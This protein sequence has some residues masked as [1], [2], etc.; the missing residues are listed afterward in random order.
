MIYFR[1]ETP[2]VLKRT[3]WTLEVMVTNKLAIKGGILVK[4]LWMILIKSHAT[5]RIFKIRHD[6]TSTTSNALY[7]AYCKLCGHHVVGPTV[8]WKPWL[9]NYKSHISKFKYSCRIVKH[10]VEVYVDTS[11]KSLFRFAW[12]TKQWWQSYQW[13]YRC[14]LLKKEKFWNSTLLTQDQAR[15]K[16]NPRL[17]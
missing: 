17:E 6:I 1:E 11:L 4:I 7:A 13:L 16:W 12:C 15:F 8:C 5:D 14:L 10:F 3:F 2:I 9:S